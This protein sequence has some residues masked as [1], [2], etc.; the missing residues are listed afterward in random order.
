MG[1]RESPRKAAPSRDRVARIAL[2]G[3]V[4]PA[5][6]RRTGREHGGVAVGQIDR[7][8]TSSLRSTGLIPQ[9]CDAG[10]VAPAPGALGLVREDT[11]W[12]RGS[13][14]SRGSPCRGAGSPPQPPGPALRRQVGIE[15][16]APEAGEGAHP[17]RVHL[18]VEA[19]GLDAGPR[20]ALVAA[21]RSQERVVA[22]P[23]GAERR[24][25]AQLAAAALL[26][27]RRGRARRAPRPSA[28]RRCARGAGSPP[29]GPGAPRA[30]ASRVASVSAWRTPV[31]TENDVDV[32][33]PARSARWQSAVLAALHAAEGIGRPR[34]EGLR[35]RSARTLE[36]RG[37]AE[38]L[39]Q[40]REVP[41]AVTRMRAF[42]AGDG[43]HRGPR[44]LRIGRPS[45]PDHRRPPRI[46]AA[47]VRRRRR[48]GAGRRG[49]SSSSPARAASA[50]RR[51]PPPRRSRSPRRASGCSWRCATPRSASRAMLGS[52][53][54]GPTIDAGRR[55]R[56]G[57]EHLAR[58]GAR[59]YGKL[60]LQSA[61]STR[62]C[63]RQQVRAGP[64]CA[65]RRGCTSGRCS[66]RPGGT[67]PSG[68][69]DGSNASTS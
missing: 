6:P 27:R 38:A 57:R 64:S 37:A 33:H 60:V 40:G 66:A 56:L 32:E 9:Y 26:R 7:G 67:P 15:T 65:R 24:A 29:A 41:G 47:N 52:R 69:A 68:C 39:V 21:Q 28:R 63:L 42:V 18:R 48:R 13:S 11:G 16:A 19:E 45:H 14:R 22:A 20:A 51:S 5:A 10:E 3:P 46:P 61:R 23:D 58:A 8:A 30:S 54:I 53:P 2:R 62:R 36:G 43:L 17:Q 59:E 31:S 12:C 4:P 35:A 50:R 44:R 25:L 1:R 34:A 55:Q 49:A